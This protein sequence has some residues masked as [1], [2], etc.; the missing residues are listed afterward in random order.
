MCK[1]WG[2]KGLVVQTRVYW[3]TGPMIRELCLI[4]L[5]CYSL[6]ELTNGALSLHRGQG[7]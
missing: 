4:I 7:K 6:S 5:Y 2:L 1:P 3:M